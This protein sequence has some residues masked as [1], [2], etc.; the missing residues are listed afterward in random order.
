VYLIVRDTDEKSYWMNITKYLKKCGD[1][2]PRTIIFN[3]DE[4]TIQAIKDLRRARL[5]EA[6]RA[7]KPTSMG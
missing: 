1:P 2:K 4:L 7:L 5:A 3:R 6:A